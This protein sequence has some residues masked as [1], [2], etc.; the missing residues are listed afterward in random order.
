MIPD[1]LFSK[2][3]MRVFMEI[4]GFW[5][6]KYVK[7][8]VQK[9]KLLND[10][11]MIVAVDKRHACQE[12]N[13]TSKKLNVVYYNRKVPL[14][15]ILNHLRLKEKKLIKEQMRTITLDRQDLSG[16]VLETKEIA[17]RLGVLESTFIEFL[18]DRRIPGYTWIGDVLIREDKLNDIRDKLERRLEED[19]LSLEEA[20]RIILERGG[21]EP[22][23][24]IESLGYKI[25]WRGIDPRSAHVLRK[26]E[27]H[28]RPIKKG[29]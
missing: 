23:G 14:K 11:E 16:P 4:V 2:A 24:I 26:S 17:K 9:L 15:P 8:K 21:K 7:N 18:R 22:I 19:E 13:A 1:F 3:N 27:N 6:P 20:T 28:V 25:E 5:T 12:F 29:Y 10:V